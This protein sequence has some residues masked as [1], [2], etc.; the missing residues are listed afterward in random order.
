[1]ETLG[2]EVSSERCG[3]YFICVG[4]LGD[5][6]TLGG[7]GHWVVMETL[8]GVDGSLTDVLVDTI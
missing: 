4:T 8:G 5:D 6:W 2:G 3:G 7:N 1:M